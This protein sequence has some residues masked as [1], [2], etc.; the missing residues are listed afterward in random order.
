M[1]R[2]KDKKSDMS[3]QCIYCGGVIRKGTIVPDWAATEVGDHVSNR[4]HA[5]LDCQNYIESIT[6]TPDEQRCI[7]NGI[8]I[9][10]RKNRKI[11]L[12]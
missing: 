3:G 6:L 1:I 12:L 9:L 11:K 5:H 4:P 2:I 8:F 10:T 7:D